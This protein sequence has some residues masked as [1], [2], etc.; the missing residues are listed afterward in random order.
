MKPA[1]SKK[2][3]WQCCWVIM[4]MTFDLTINMTTWPC[5]GYVAT[6]LAVKA[7]TMHPTYHVRYYVN[8]NVVSIEIIAAAVSSK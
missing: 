7:L 4:A 8:T 2:R 6:F 1:E 5:L 3:N